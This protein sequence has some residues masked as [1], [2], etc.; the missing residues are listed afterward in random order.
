MKPV[1]SE[2]YDKFKGDCLRAS[3]AS[4]FDLELCQVP[5]FRLFPDE[6]ER[7]I[8]SGFYWGMGYDWVK[9]G[10]PGKEELKI[11]DSVNGFFEACVISS[12]GDDFTHSVVIDLNGVVVHDPNKN[13]S[14]KGENVFKNGALKW[15]TITKKQNREAWQ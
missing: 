8:V 11:E 7:F 13:N 9:V 4:I 14:I 10:N 15:W 5:H 12:Y 6:Q 3:I 2:V 1:Y